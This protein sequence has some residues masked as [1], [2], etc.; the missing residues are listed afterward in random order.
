MRSELSALCGSADARV[1]LDEACRTADRLDKLDALLQGD[2]DVWCRLVHD[3]RTEDYELKIDAALSEARQQAGALRLLIESIRKL[4]P[5]GE[6][7]AAPTEVSKADE[8]AARRADRRSG[9]GDPPP[10]GR[11]SQSRRSNGVHRTS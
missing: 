10:A 9:P 8:L 6:E 3:L 4:A 5:K 1:L 11:R 7:P 2:A